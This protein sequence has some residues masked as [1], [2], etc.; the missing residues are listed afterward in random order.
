MSIF[1]QI[2]TILKLYIMENDHKIILKLNWRFPDVES[3]T[4]GSSRSF[5]GGSEWYVLAHSTSWIFSASWKLNR[6]MNEKLRRSSFVYLFF[7]L[8]IW[9]KKRVLKD[10]LSNRIV[11]L[12]VIIKLPFLPFITFQNFVSGDLVVQHHHFFTCL[13]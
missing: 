8:L 13:F 1:Q 5:V 2:L 10:Q 4:T 12:I 3:S 11:N 6:K 9:S 7:F